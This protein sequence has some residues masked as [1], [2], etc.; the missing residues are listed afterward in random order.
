[1]ADTENQ[2]VQTGAEA[3]PETLTAPAPDEGPATEAPVKRKRG[4][5]A[6]TE[7]EKAARAKAAGKSSAKTAKAKRGPYSNDEISTMGNQI[8]GLHLMASMALGIPELQLQAQEGERLAK[9]I[10]DVAIEYDLALDGKTGAALNLILCAGI[11]YGPRFMMV[12]ARAK[13]EKAK[14][15]DMGTVEIV[16]PEMNGYGANPS[17]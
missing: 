9:A 4:R 15:R 5:P 6:M 1:M 16:H 12:T 2:E 10:T 11:T 8:V 7:A 17:H 14:P 13:A 3:G